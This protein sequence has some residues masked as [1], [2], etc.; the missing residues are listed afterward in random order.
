[1]DN[2]ISLLVYGVS[3]VF[4]Y[5]MGRLS[6]KYGWNETMPIPVQ[7]VIVALICFSIVYI[8]YRPENSA[9]LFGQIASAIGGSGTAALI[10]DASKSNKGGDK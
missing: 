3:T 4:T 1:M 6:K 2:M 5:I 8:I 10:Y 9:D 7:N